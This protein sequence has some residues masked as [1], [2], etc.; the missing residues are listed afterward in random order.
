MPRCQKKTHVLGQDLVKPNHGEGLA[1]HRRGHD[2]T[3]IVVLVNFLGGNTV[4]KAEFG[5]RT[6][7]L[8]MV[9]VRVVWQYG[10][11]WSQVHLPLRDKWRV[12][13]DAYF[14]RERTCQAAPGNSTRDRGTSPTP[15]SR[16]ANVINTTAKYKS[17]HQQLST[18][19]RNERQHRAFYNKNKHVA[20]T[21]K[22]NQQ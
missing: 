22:L 4:Q 19:M 9:G 16:L 7:N 18:H 12:E 3:H 13:R 14:F 10:I 8:R 2:I 1:M 11:I 17:C 20:E 21:K 6:K 15:S 5:R